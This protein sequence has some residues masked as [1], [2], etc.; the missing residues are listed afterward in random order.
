MNLQFAC[1]FVSALA[2]CSVA[3]AESPD[4]APSIRTCKAQGDCEFG[5]GK[6]SADEQARVKRVMQMVP[7]GATE[8]QISERL[9]HLPFKRG[10][11]LSANIVAPGATSSKS[12]WSLEN[13]PSHNPMEE[14]FDVLFINDRAVKLSWWSSGMFPY[15]HVDFPS[16]R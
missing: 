14:H 10:P 7:P 8:A 3:S 11:K 4:S 16:Q 2:V 6:L 9:G 5:W 15:A 13:P 12:Y 1:A